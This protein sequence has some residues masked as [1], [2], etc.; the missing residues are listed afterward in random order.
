MFAARHFAL[1][2]GLIG[3]FAAADAHA[4]EAA[5]DP[6][7]APR[8]PEQAPPR[9]EPPDDPARGQTLIPHPAAQKP[10]SIPPFAVDPVADGALIIG[11]GVFSYLLD[12]VAGTPGA[13][14]ADTRG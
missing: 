13:P 7:L 8:P 12:Q 1:P 14:L 10:P 2:L 4:Q 5:S 11:S 3:L 9:I 6:P